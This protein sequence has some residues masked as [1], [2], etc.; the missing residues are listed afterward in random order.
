MAKLLVSAPRRVTKTRVA[1]VEGGDGQEGVPEQEDAPALVVDQVV[2]PGR[3]ETCD[4]TTCSTCTW[5]GWGCSGGC[6]PTR[7]CPAPCGD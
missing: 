4:Y 5:E 3:G 2:E 1:P 7:C 6:S